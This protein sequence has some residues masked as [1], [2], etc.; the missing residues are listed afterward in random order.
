MIDRLYEEFVEKAIPPETPITYN[1]TCVGHT[2][3][4][5]FMGRPVKVMLYPN[6][7][8]VMRLCGTADVCSLEIRKC[9]DCV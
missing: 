4:D 2:I 3:G 9:D 6:A 1:G 5:N 8:G 7:Y